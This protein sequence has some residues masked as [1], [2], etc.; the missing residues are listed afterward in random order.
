MTSRWMTFGSGWLML[1]AGAC[2]AHGALPD[3]RAA[4]SM[5]VVE[6]SRKE[7]VEVVMAK[8]TPH[9][10]TL[11]VERPM[12]TPG[13]RFDVNT[14]DIEPE[15]S[16]IMVR[17]RETGP[18]GVSS[19]VITPTRLEIPLGAIPR[20]RYFLELWTRRADDQPHVPS[21]AWVLVAG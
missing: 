16:R 9:R 1:L 15:S 20:G 19:Q 8:S 3:H 11:V 18:T 7:R 10:F 14:I 6:E 5:R 17:V 13:W 12:P 4:T 21:R 2:A